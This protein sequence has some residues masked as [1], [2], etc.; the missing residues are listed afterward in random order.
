LRSK[1]FGVFEGPEAPRL[2]LVISVC[3]A[4]AREPCPVWPGAPASAHWSLPDPAAVE[5][6]PAERR[7]AFERVLETLRRHLQALL[8][9]PLAELDRQSLASRVN[10]IP[11]AASEPGFRDSEVES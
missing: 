2:D 5:G 9:L 10:A 4:A 3:D 7:A 1:G 8:A 6:T 11:A